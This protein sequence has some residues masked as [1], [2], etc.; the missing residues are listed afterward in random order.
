[1]YRDFIIHVETLGKKKVPKYWDY[2]HNK[3][4]YER[5][6]SLINKKWW[7]I[8]NSKEIFKKDDNN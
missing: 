2:E 1:M 7:D 6:L 8:Q 4:K 3:N 5:F